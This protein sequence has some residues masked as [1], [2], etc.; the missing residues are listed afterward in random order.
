MDKKQK[1]LLSS[2]VI[3]LFHVAET[4]GSDTK[5]EMHFVLVHGSC[6]GA[7]SWYKVVWLLRKSGHRVSAIDLAASGINPVQVNQIPS[8]SDY[9]K[10]LRDFMASLSPHEKVVL[11][12]HSFG[13]LAISQAME[14]FPEKISVAVFVTAMMPGPALN[15]STLSQESFKGNESLLDSRYTYDN[16]PNNPA[17]TFIFGPVYL[18][19]KVYQLSPPED[20]ALA[21]TL[22]R[23]LWLYSQENMAKEL[24]FTTEKYGSVK[25]VFIVSE[26]DQV[27]KKEFQEWMIEKNPP[28][29][30]EQI[31]GSDHMVMMSRPLELCALLHAISQKYC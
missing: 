27:E 26:K 4:T 23:P 25:R 13:G 12:G 3:F 15:I 2:L 30:V 1:I 10:P 20:V 21:M 18:A 29:E 5:Q 28:D 9:F 22:L 6:H 16:G 8:I 11:V 17:T 14:N 24:V 19:K 31:A 7:W